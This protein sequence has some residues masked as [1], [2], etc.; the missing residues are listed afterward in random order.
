MKREAP[1]LSIFSCTF[2]F[3]STAG[4]AATRLRRGLS[5]KCCLFLDICG[6]AGS[7][8][9]SQVGEFGEWNIREWQELRRKAQT[10]PHGHFTFKDH[11]CYCE[12]Y[13][14]DWNTL[15]DKPSVLVIK[16]EVCSAVKEVLLEMINGVWL[17]TR[18][19]S[20]SLK[21]SSLIKPSWQHVLKT[22][23]WSLILSV[24]SNINPI[25]TFSPQFTGKCHWNSHLGW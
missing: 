7:S 1:D 4:F 16:G 10:T 13:L 22:G 18:V 11:N 20:P 14:F 15:T 8:G 17:R 9:L 25:D 3:Q 21:M 19:A 24:V 23:T 2:T 5:P 6:A 12:I